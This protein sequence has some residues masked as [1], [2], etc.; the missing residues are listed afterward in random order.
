MSP[1]EAI[2]Q[3]EETPCEP[4]Y[5]VAQL[6]VFSFALSAPAHGETALARAFAAAWQRQPAAA[7]LGERERAVAAQR[8]AAEQGR[9]AAAERRSRRP[10]RPF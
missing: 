10:Q 8:A 6:L 7:A 2:Q 5:G 3:P 1:V 4:F 9:R